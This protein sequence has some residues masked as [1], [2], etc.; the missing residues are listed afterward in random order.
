MQSYWSK[1]KKSLLWT[2]IAVVVIFVTSLTQMLIQTAGGSIRVTDLRNA[3]N[4]GT[5][6]Q[7]ATYLEGEE[8]KETTIETTLKGEVVSGL[9]FKPN[10]ASKENKRPG[11]VLTHGYLN[12]RELQLPFAIELARRGY[13]VLAVDREGHGNYENVDGTPAVMNTKGLYESAKYLYNLD[14]VDQTKIG[15]SGHSMGGMTTAYTLMVDDNTKPVDTLKKNG[16]DYT[17]YGLGV[18]KAGLIQA[19][20][21]FMGASPTTSVGMLKANDDEFF[22]GSTDSE[23]NATIAR[24]FLH[25]VAAANFVGVPVTPGQEI[26]IENK[27]TYVN[28]QIKTVELGTSLAEEYG[29]F[30]AIYEENEIHPLNHF[31]IPSTANL[32]HFFYDAFGA[33]T[34]VLGLKNQVWWVKEMFSFIGMLALL[35]LIFPL[36]SL[37]LTVPF[38]NSLAKRRKVTADQEGRLIVT[39]I[40][41]TPE[42]IDGEKKPVKKW[43]QYVM[44]FIP[45]IACTIFSGFSI[46]S[47]FNEWGPRWF[48]LTPYFPQDTTNNVAFWSVACGLFAIIIVAL[49]FAVNYG[50][51][52]V[53]TLKGIE[54]EPVSNPFAVARIDSF[55]NFVKTFVLA[56]FIVFILYFIVFI[57]WAIFVVDFRLWTL[58]IKVFNVP[59]M[60]PT[61]FR[62]LIFFGIFYVLAGIANQ[63][64]RAKNLPDWATIAINAFFNVFGIC[65]VIII[66]YATFKST[67][68]LW[69]P[70]MNLTYIVLFPIV[71]ILIMATIISRLL[72]KKTGNIW[73][74]S[75]I[76]A[77]LF[78]MMTVANTAASYPYIM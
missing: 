44:Y 67:G 69:Q 51:N 2:L 27:A 17:L 77:M 24:E 23:G 14:Y 36:V 38:F 64:Y 8:L 13:V 19:F 22:Y 7:R 29:A 47:F 63:T 43:Y 1:H 33:P 41:V 58:D 20:A 21:P 62:Y 66:Q 26:N 65:L 60:L 75:F 50:I 15:I 11:I 35:S 54:T 31:S 55:K 68:V 57:N 59:E 4:T 46:Q 32:V 61:A 25:S 37:L 56:L 78:T 71:P 34:K 49:A 74:G 73:L 72:Y 9:L 30:R 70:D 28:G 16:V 42:L 53:K 45:A 39:D 76:N 6:A 3:T 52:K 18:V 40:V 48:P 5:I 12:N 10:A